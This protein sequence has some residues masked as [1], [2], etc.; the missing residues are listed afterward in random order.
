MRPGRVLLVGRGSFLARHLLE[1]LPPDEVRAV[2]HE[3]IDEPGLLD[4]VRC[5]V[6]Y[7]RHP[8]IT[9]DDYDLEAQDTDLRLARRIGDRDV[10]FIM[11]SSRKVYAPRAAPLAEDAPVGP[12][13]AYGRNKRAA[14]EALRERLGERLTV[15]RLGNIFGYERA[16]GRRTFLSVLLENLAREG[17]IRYDMS[18]FVERD[19][20]PVERLAELL[21]PISAQPPGG[22]INVGSGIGLPTGRMALWILEGFGRGELV[23]AS[24]REHD[25]F[26]LDV[27]RLRSLYGEPCTLGDLRARCLDLGRQLAAEVGSA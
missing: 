14:E 5:V 26:V 18:P 3:A 27:G 4:G 8:A 13:D 6:N 1:R 22:V 24:P 9:R 11:L 16:P 25:P 2:R 21:V 12:R 10:C 7:T 19:F 20:L 15:L 23:I 17:R